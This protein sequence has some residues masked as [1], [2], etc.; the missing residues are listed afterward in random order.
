M[1]NLKRALALVVATLTLGVL[2][3]APANAQTQ[4]GLVNV[5]VSEVTIQVPVAVA[6]NLCELNVNVIARQF[7]GPGA[8]CEA[9][10]VSDAEAGEC[11]A[12]N[13]ANQQGLVNVNIQDVCVQLPIGIAANVCEVN[14]NVLAEQ[15]RQGR[16][17]VCEAF[18]DPDAT[19]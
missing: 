13:G 7:R 14:A 8:S 9:T 5:N 10:A 3:V 15:R 16:A 6:A 4:E 17:A 18:A 1:N 12:G 11:P 19:A 2:A